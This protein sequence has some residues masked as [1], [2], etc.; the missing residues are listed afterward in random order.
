MSLAA[1]LGISGDG[2]VRS[3]GL[4]SDHETRP[5]AALPMAGDAAEPQE[6]ADLVGLER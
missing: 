1:R 2:D 6:V 3:F 5:H 4:I